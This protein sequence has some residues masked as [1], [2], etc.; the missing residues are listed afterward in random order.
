MTDGAPQNDPLRQAI[1][2][3]NEHRFDQALGW[4]QKLDQSLLSP[5]DQGRALALEIVCLAHQDLEDDAR[6]LLTRAQRRHGDDTALQL[7][8]GIQLSELGAYE[9][10]EKVLRRLGEKLPA[11]PLPLYNLGLVLERDARFDEAVNMYAEAIAKDGN[12]DYPPFRARRGHVLARL[13]KLNEAV[14]AY[15]EY[16][17]LVPEDA[18]EWIALAIVH[19]DAGHYEQAGEAY[20]KAHALDPDSISL[21]FNWATTA[22]R[23]RDRT[24]TAACLTALERLAPDDWRSELARAY[25]AEQEGAAW[26]GWE[27][28]QRAVER[29]AELSEAA[30]HDESAADPAP[31]AACAA[32]WY[33]VRNRLADHAKPFVEQLFEHQLFDENILGALRALEGTRCPKARDFHVLLEGELPPEMDE[34]QRNDP[35]ERADVESDACRFFRSYRVWAEDSDQAG[36]FALE[37][38]RRC[39]G[40]ALEVGAVEQQEETREAH[41]GVAWCSEAW[42]Y[43]EGDDEEDEDA[44]ED[45]EEGPN[46]DELE[47]EAEAEEEEDQEDEEG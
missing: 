11:D 22:S 3:L 36:R 27:A 32:L 9:W 35:F 39:G 12:A 2:L 47:A 40:R 42:I 26:Q 44:E 23:Q 6:R 31:A 17:A 34:E 15:R 41:L 4:L 28:C 1:E 29:A 5:K 16:L 21:H 24:Q 45:E 8:L 20:R 33:A 43:E 7:A 13:G 38:E 18:H 37:F 19:S 14:A 10:A 46:D 30:E 25:L